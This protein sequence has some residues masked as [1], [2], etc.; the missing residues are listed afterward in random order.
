L[1]STSKKKDIDL[2][3][4]IIWRLKKSIHLKL[5]V[6]GLR[7]LNG[8]MDYWSA[9]VMRPILHSSITP[10]TPAPLLPNRP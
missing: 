8:V 6:T 9:E 7:Y 5:A 3:L 10:I 4:A 1:I 2:L